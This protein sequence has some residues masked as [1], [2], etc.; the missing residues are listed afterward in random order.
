MHRC[1]ASILQYLVDYED[2]SAL[3]RRCS[4]GGSFVDRKRRPKRIRTV[5]G[6]IC[7]VRTVQRCDGCGRW[8]V[9]EDVVLDVVGTGFSP[10]LRRMMAKT[11]AELCFDKARDL[12]QELSGLS[13][14]D[15]Q[16][17][18]VAETVGEQIA[19]EQERRVE[20][21][22]SGQDGPCS[23]SPS[24]L[25]IATDGTGVPVLR[26]ESEGREGKSNDGVARTREVKLGAI[27]TQTT[28]NEHGMP[29]R[30]PLSTTY[31]GKI[32][33]ADSFGPRL[34]AEALRRGLTSAKRVAFIGDAAAWIWNLADFH[35]P[36]ACQIIDYYHAAEHLG[37]LSRLLFPDDEQR[38]SQWLELVC[39]KLWHGKLSSVISELRA[40]PVRG[41]KKA[42]VQKQ[43]AF[44]IK[45]RKRMRYERF[46][47]QGLFIGSGVVEAGCKT[48][49]AARLKRSGMHWSVRGANAIIALR[50]CLESGDFDDFWESRQPP[51]A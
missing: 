6:Q 31:V 20:L 7:P 5:V 37:E 23:H 10:G 51:A 42:L 12:I 9:A 25:Y 19:R 24:T 49:I 27:F 46:R 30:D 50:C 11:G 14:T 26:T 1:G 3:E 29:Q 43:I 32:E 2:G 47:N 4:C 28:V 44:F 15:K 17:E 8:R 13:V 21:A 18:R 40:L 22:M 34:Y 41:K 16:V 48:V 39:D 45:N 38:K 33:S 36:G 35:F